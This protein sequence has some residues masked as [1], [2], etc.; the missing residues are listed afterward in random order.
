[1]VVIDQYSLATVPLEMLFNNTSL[2]IGTGFLWSI[3][4]QFF[5]ITNWHNLSGRDPFTGKHLSKTAAAPNELRIWWN[6]KGKLG[7]K[8]AAVHDIR[9][10]QGAPLWWIHPTHGNKVDVVA[11]PVA[12]HPNANMYPINSMPTS[13]LVI[14]IG[15]DVFVLGY[16]F[17][18]GPAGLPIWKRGSI[19]SEPDL[20]AA[21]QLHILVDTASR[22][23]MSGSPVIRRSWGTHMLEGGNISMGAGTATKFA[24]VYSGR[25]ASTDPLDAQLGLT[26]PA[27][28]VAEIVAGARRDS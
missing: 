21:G 8:F 22:P 11:L 2:S 18:I 14:Q 5:L 9:D 20:A 16:P 24:G 23:G 6:T 19:A 27:S 28:L 15:M 1:V 10:A 25:L 13:P 26:W 4:N 12:K 17:G 3:D 7:E